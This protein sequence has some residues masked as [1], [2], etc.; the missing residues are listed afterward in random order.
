MENK[1]ISNDPT[2]EKNFIGH[3]DVITALSFH[4]NTDQLISSSHDKKIILWNLTKKKSAYKF[5][6]HKESVLDVCYSSDGSSMAS[7]SRDRSVRIWTPKV[8]GSSSSFKA[9]NSDVTSLQ[10]SPDDEKLATASNDKNIKLWYTQAQTFFKSF[11][12]HTHWVRCIKFSPDGRL[13]VSCSDDKTIKVWDITSGLC[14]KTFN[15]LKAP[16]RYVE[17]HPNGIYI[18]TC[19]DTFVK[20]Y[21]LRTGALYQCY[22]SHKKTVNMIK[23]HPTGHFM[24]T[25]S[26]DSTM[27]ILDLLE[28]RPIYTLK[29]PSYKTAI[30]SIAFSKDG[31]FFA[32]GGTDRQILLWKLNLSTD[33]QNGEFS[34]QLHLPVIREK[35]DVDEIFSISDKHEEDTYKKQDQAKCLLDALEKSDSESD[36]SPDLSTPEVINVKNIKSPKTRRSKRIAKVPILQNQILSASS[37]NQSIKKIDVLYDEVQL[38]R[39]NINMLERRLITLEEQFEK[40]NSPGL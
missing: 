9:H 10:F 36:S 20:L 29:G 11:F 40:L 30:T 3:T 1:K 13:L 28:G 26:D 4:P 19:M 38:I 8:K 21:D 23:F 15:Q 25:A 17:F 5:M 18:G 39:Q 7:A 33:K 16:A 35:S 2:Y 6:G 27:K 34:K 24:L 14:V 22:N 37:S 32:S 12:E 31:E